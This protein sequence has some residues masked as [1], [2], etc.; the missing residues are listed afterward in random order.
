MLY[1]ISQQ[2]VIW[3]KTKMALRRFV[4]YHHHSDAIL[5][6]TSQVEGSFQQIVEGFFYE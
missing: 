5:F 6:L 2:I 1:H 3:I 4:S